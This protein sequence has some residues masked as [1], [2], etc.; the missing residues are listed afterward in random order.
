MVEI[1]DISLFEIAKE[2]E[3]FG[4]VV[5]AID[6]IHKNPN[7]EIE[8]KNIYDRLDLQ[9]IFSGSSAIKIEHSK[10]DLSRRAI[11]RKVKNLSFREFVELSLDKNFDSFSLEDILKNHTDIALN[12]QKEFKIYELFKEYLKFGAYPYYFEDK[13]RYKE[14][15]EAT[16]N[17]VVEVDL[18]SIF[19][20]KYENII[21]LKKLLKLLCNSKPYELNISALSKKI[22]IGRDKLYTYIHYLSKG[23]IL[24]PIYQKSR[25][26]SIFTKPAKLYLYNSNLYQAYC[27]NSEIGT[28]RESFFANQLYN[29][30]EI[31]YSKQGDFLVDN[32][33]TF[34]IGGKNK[35]F[36]QIADV[37]NSYVVADDIEIGFG[38]KIPLWLFGFLY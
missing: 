31:E 11:I 20:I 8:L 14:R 37:P 16:I 9:V 2:F 22:G 5:L 12:L 13:L 33:Y 24:L 29:F 34:E 23:S 35:S 27:K 30:Y 28:I 38:N 10:A 7:F 18:A 19:S 6:E 36:K 15:L 1:S 17:I 4:G 25:G 26:D 3:R 32:K 21:N